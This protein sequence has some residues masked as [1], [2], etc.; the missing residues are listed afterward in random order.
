MVKLSRNISRDGT[1]SPAMF[2][3]PT[4]RKKFADALIARD[5]AVFSNNFPSQLKVKMI[6]G[7]PAEEYKEK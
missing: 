7:M 4:S 1:Y 3:T 2:A 5:A 6:G